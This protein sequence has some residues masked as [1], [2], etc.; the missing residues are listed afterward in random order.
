[1]EI[2]RFRDN[3]SD[4]LENRLPVSERKAMEA[5]LIASP[6]A[7]ADLATLKDTW[8]GLDSWAKTSTPEPPMF[9]RDNVLSAIERSSTRRGQWGGSQQTQ[10]TIWERLFPN[11]GR[12]AFA[13]GVGGLVAI[14][15]FLVTNTLLT[16]N[17][18]LQVAGVG[19]P[20]AGIASGLIL[21]YAGQVA[22]N[23]TAEA[24]PRLVISTGRTL[25]PDAHSVCEF[26]FWLENTPQGSARFTVL[27]DNPSS[28]GGDAGKIFNYPGLS[29]SGAQTLR[30]P[31]DT[32][33]ASA[34]ALKVRWTASGYVHDRYLFVP[35]SATTITENSVAVIPSA[36][37]L[38]EMPLT[39][40]L[41]K[42]AMATNVPVTVENISAV[43]TLRAQISADGKETVSMALRRSLAPLGLRV[44]RSSSGILVTAK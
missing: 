23:D 29:S 20:I 31:F 39:D 19:T 36:F 27:G 33:K 2:S 41:Q 37:T 38:A 6:E 28:S 1:M 34:L 32:Q 44:S 22:E 17:A 18:S 10:Q 8:Q 11:T 16:P 9:F 35:T 4:Y 13:A 25:T 3:L 42:V 21:P 14:A 24:I 40:A 5:H 12:L 26:T 30:V 15:G 43:E 7:R